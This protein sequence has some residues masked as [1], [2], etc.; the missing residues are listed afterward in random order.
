MTSIHCRYIVASLIVKTNLSFGVLVYDDGEDEDSHCPVL[1]LH[2]VVIQDLN[3]VL[4]ATVLHQIRLAGLREET[5]SEEGERGEGGREGARR[6]GGGREGGGR[7]GGEREGGG[8]EGGRGRGGREGGGR[9]G[10]GREG[11]RGDGGST[12]GRGH[13][14]KW[15]Q[16]IGGQATQDA[17]AKPAPH[18]INGEYLCPDEDQD[19]LQFP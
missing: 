12:R 9:E 7:E 1:I 4:V 15:S 2:G 19:G 3:E 13:I 14:Y 8:R 17:L 18:R 10:R 5:R 11:G 16:N 6:E